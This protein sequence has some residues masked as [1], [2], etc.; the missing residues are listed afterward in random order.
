[1]FFE[2]DWVVIKINLNPLEEKSNFPHLGHTVNFN[3]I[4][5]LNLYNNLWKA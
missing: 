1:M 2:S 4:N 5:W 3:S